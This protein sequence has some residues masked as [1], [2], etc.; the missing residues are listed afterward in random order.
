[1]EVAYAPGRVADVVGDGPTV[2]LWHGSGP[3]ERRALARLAAAVATSGHRTVTPDWDVTSSDGGRADLLT[4]LRFARETADHDP[5]E[6]VLVGWS[7]GGVAAAGLT[8]N[9]RRLGIGLAR[10]VC[11]AA[12]PFPRADPIS[13]AMLGPASPPVARGT[14]VVF[15]TGLRDE[16]T[17]I[18]EVRAVHRQWNQV[19][20][21]TTLHELD[22]DHFSV[23]EDHAE[24]VA[25]VVVG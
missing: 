23:V 6:L 1:M 4:S 5:D 19:G 25:A 13:G 14:T 8:L 7:R 2:L 11:V 17:P 10:T 3:N 21:P 16:R 20:W 9:Q 18:D 15:V 12:A 22:A 24:D